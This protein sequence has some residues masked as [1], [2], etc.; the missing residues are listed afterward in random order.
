MNPVKV[1]IARQPSDAERSNW[2]EKHG[3]TPDADGYMDA[4][5]AGEAPLN[6]AG[7]IEQVRENA[8]RDDVPNLRGSIYQEATMVFVA[9]GPSL[10]KFVDEIKAKCSD[11]R[12]DVYTSN[13]TCKWMLV[14]G[15]KPKYHVIIDPMERKKID[16]EYEAEDVTMV[17]GLQCHP[18]VFDEAKA[19]N[20][21]ALKFLA[22]STTRKNSTVSDAEAAQAA[23]TPKN[24]E[25][26]AI[27]G[28]SMCGTRMIYLAAALGYRR[29]EFYGLDGCSDMLP[30][31]VV[32]NYAYPK[33]RGETIIEVEAANGRKFHSTVSFAR[34]ADELVKLL[35]N[36]PGLDV[37]IHG[38]SFMSNQ[39]AMYKE[40]HKNAPYRMSEAYKA[41]QEGFHDVTPSYG[42]S[43]SEHASR[44]FLGAAQIAK[45]YG[46]CDVLDYGCGKE[47]LRLSIEESFPSVGGVR[48][49][50]YDPGRKGYDAEPKPADMVVCTDVM[51][52][53]EPE[54]VDAVLRH[55]CELTKHVAI[56]DVALTP[57]QKILPDG[58]NAHICLKSKDWWLS[59]I[60]KYF[61]LIEQAANGHALLVVGQPIQKW[62]ERLELKKA[63]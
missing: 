43:G 2:Y 47:T 60:K 58:R 29:L 57:A 61:V 19:R 23:V 12:Y 13:N 1:E 59:F 42:T 49:I 20:R 28:G 48:V 9:G 17:L 11:P 62:R 50:G 30:N 21:K 32:N 15:M 10:N 37:E 54:C 25:L 22:A 33:P 14:N 35:E 24:P 41:L 36:L 7:I 39:L 44:V 45:K 63:A 27:G 55:I 4:L 52:H 40:L 31:G 34:Q 5:P 18:A 8:K 38:D 16:L 3:L 53:I 46:S 51:E 26:I 6:D 56:I